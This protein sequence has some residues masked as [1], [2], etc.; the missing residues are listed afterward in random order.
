MPQKLIK[1]LNDYQEI[2][3]RTPV[4]VFVWRIVPDHSIEFVSDNVQKYL[5]YSAEDFIS[6][7]VL[8]TDI[9]YPEDMPSFEAEHTS[10]RQPGGQEFV[11]QYRLKTKSGEYRWFEDRTSELV[12]ESGN[13]THCQSIVIDITERKLMEDRLRDGERF[14]SN[15]FSSVQDGISVID[16]DFNIVR[17]NPTMNRYYTNSVPLI[18]K[19][20]Y[21]AYHSQ[22][23]PCEACPSMRTFENG[24]PAHEVMSE[25][26]SGEDAMRWL[27]MYTF[28]LIDMDTGEMNGVIEYAR[29]ITKRKNAEESLK[30]NEAKFR[31]LFDLANDAIFLLDGDK[32][33]DC[34]D[35][36]L[37]MFGYTNEEMIGKELYD[38]SP[39]LQP[40][41]R[42]SKEKSIERINN[43]IYGEPQF[44]EWKHLRQDG[45]VFDAEVSLSLF[46]FKDNVFTQS[47]VRDVTYRKRME[48]E[49]VK[50]KNLESIGTLAGGIAHDFNNLLMV[51]MGNI[52]L[53]K[54]HLSPDSKAVERLSDAENASIAAKD[55]TQQLITFSRGGE[56]WKKIIAVAPVIKS[57]ARF[58]LSGSRIKCKYFLSDSLHP[59]HADE[60]QLRQVVHNIMNNSRE[61]MP[62]GG[63]ITI[64]AENV[65]ITQKDNVP[66]PYGDY[67]KISI[68]DKGIGIKEEYLSKIF[69]PYFST[70]GMGV[71]KGMGLG[72]S[73]SYSIIKKHAGYILLESSQGVGTTVQIYLPAYKKEAEGVVAGEVIPVKGRILVMD[74]VE[75]VRLVTSNMLIKLGYEVACAEDGREAVELYK[76]AGELDAPFDA[77]ILDLTVQGG[78]GGKEALFELLS[79]DP[80]VKA[81]I[82]SGYTDDPIIDNFREF[83]FKAAVIKPYKMEEL[84]EVLKKLIPHP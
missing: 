46:K 20:C 9:I 38:F 42:D 17:V 75:E 48:E 5:G 59:V 12:D 16:K 11:R 40:D 37:E 54:L 61:A 36:T 19:K 72:L 43:A 22:E 55:L 23:K 30:E 63:V 76:Q 53:A 69:D 45:T 80:Y 28:P 78:M 31:T 14:L 15:I 52:S 27:D 57:T 49:L 47:I 24:K 70:K 25:R 4:V 44:F 3:N 68:E 51:I 66:L 64:R 41:G 6:G 65:V 29:D 84:E 58:V 18:G 13:A 7:R 50:S 10:C 34:N 35:K 79:I 56:P 26:S 2:I 74:D 32:V 67:V 1:R 21:E 62:A 33:V 73:V 83:G 71:Q 77:V 81:L 39:P 8:L 60:V 82:A